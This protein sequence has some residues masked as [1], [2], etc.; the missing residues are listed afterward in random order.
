[1][2][3]QEV[4]EEHKQSEGDPIIKS[5]LRSLRVQRAR[6]RMMS[7]VPNADVVVTNPTHF[8]CALKYD[9][10]SMQAPVLVAKGQDLVA[11]RIRQIA[12]ENEVPVVENPPLARALF[13]T[14]DI[15]REIPP[16][17]YKAVAEVISYVMRI[18][19]K[20]RK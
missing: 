12:E 16:E 17:H 8:A 6:Q 9:G 13:A 1:M 15:D 10:E 11:L 3:K 5:R 20:R 7:A 14:V 2:T 19:G 18:K 4:K